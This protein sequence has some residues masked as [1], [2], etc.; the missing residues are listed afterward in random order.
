M[1]LSPVHP[2]IAGLL[3]ARVFT[4]V[5]TF[6]NRLREHLSVLKRLDS[7]GEDVSTGLLSSMKYLSVLILVIP[8]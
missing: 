7:C 1:S 4:S 8:N 6:M 5:L 2:R 3:V